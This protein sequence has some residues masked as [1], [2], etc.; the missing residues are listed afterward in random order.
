M[1][2]VNT[3][4]TVKLEIVRQDSEN[5]ATRVEKFEVPYRPKV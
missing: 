4:R 5:G 1:E 3:G 2:T